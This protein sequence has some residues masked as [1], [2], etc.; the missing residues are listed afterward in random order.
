MGPAVDM[1]HA[2]MRPLALK[3]TEVS[4]SAKIDG[5]NKPKIPV[6]KNTGKKPTLKPVTNS[7]PKPPPLKRPKKKGT[8]RKGKKGDA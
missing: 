4:F 6:E 5:G 8:K 3:C 7:T 2:V 1:N